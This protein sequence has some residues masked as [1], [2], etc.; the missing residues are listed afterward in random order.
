MIGFICF[1]VF[2]ILNFINSCM[3]TA[4]YEVFAWQY[5]V[6]LLCTCGCYLA[7]CMHYIFKNRR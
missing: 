2:M 1:I 3:I 7:G 4:A 6:G 5:W